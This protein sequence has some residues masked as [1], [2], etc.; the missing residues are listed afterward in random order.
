M[1]VS[2]VTSEIKVTG[3]L[4]V[5]FTA[6][7]AS[8][9]Q[10]VF[11]YVRYGSV[12]TSPTCTDTAG[13]TYTALTTIN[14]GSTYI[15]S[16]YSILTASNASNVV[17]TTNT[18]STVSTVAAVSV[19]STS[20][21]AFSF[22]TQAGDMPGYA[23]SPA[24]TSITTAAAGIIV[25][26]CDAY[27]SNAGGDTVTTPT[28][29]TSRTSQAASASGSAINVFDYITS[30]SQSSLS[31][32]S[33]SSLGSGNNTRL[34]IKLASFSSPL[35]PTITAQ[36]TNQFAL[37]G[38][39]ATFSVTATASGG[40]LSYQWYVNSGL[41]TGA[42][43]SG[44]TTPTLTGTNNGDLYYVVVTDSN[45]SVTS[46]TV[47]LSVSAAGLSTLGQ[48]DPEMRILGWF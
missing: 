25:G 13:N 10:L 12:P 33:A 9:G 29:F 17:S 3:S 18:N 8:V 44:Y 22:D 36:P 7:N 43:S 35:G 37:T 26:A 39:T 1:A 38:G 15:Y 46:S 45:G 34:G 24:T 27:Y 5:N 19:Y 20:G 11:V 42:T 47:R 40:S 14:D 32:S 21:A 6:F 41:I 16:F 48:F 30:A 2:Y 4:P 28:S 23:V 31:V